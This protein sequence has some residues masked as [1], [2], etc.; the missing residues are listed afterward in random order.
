[1]AQTT[2]QSPASRGSCLLDHLAQDRLVA[3]VDA[4]KVTDGEYTASVFGPDIVNTS[5]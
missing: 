3:K 2:S 4:I 5:N 1:M